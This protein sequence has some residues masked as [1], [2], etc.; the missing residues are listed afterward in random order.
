MISQIITYIDDEGQE[1]KC[2]GNKAYID[3]IKKSCRQILE[4]L[5]IKH[6]EK[7]RSQI[8]ALSIEELNMVLE[9]YIDD[10]I[11]LVDRPN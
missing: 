9:Q 2:I 11:L 1:V 6:S 4:I 3:N 10:N 7:Q 8:M 5:T